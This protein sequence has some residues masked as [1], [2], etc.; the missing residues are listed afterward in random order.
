[1]EERYREVIEIDADDRSGP[2]IAGATRR[3]DGLRRMASATT[4][5]L[6]MLGRGLANVAAIASG[7]VIGQALY[8]LPNLLASAASGARDDEAA[9]LRLEQSIRNLGG[10]FDTNLARVNDA[11]TAGQKLAFTDDEI[12]DSYQFLATATDSSNEALRRQRIALDFARGANIPLAQ[13]SKL[14]GKVTQENIQQFKRLGI[15]IREG[16]TEQEALAAIQ[17]KFAGQAEIYANSSK[18]QAEAANMAFGEMQETLG[19]S[20]LPLLTRLGRIVIDNLPALQSM[21]EWIGGKLSAGVGLALDQLE[22]LQRLFVKWKPALSTAADL[23][24]AFLTAI[25]TDPG[26]LG[27]VGDILERM[28]GSKA[29]G[30]MRSFLQIGMSLI[31]TVGRSAGAFKNLAEGRITVADVLVGIRT[32]FKDFGA[33]VWREVKLLGTRVL[34]TFKTEGPKWVRASWNWVKSAAKSAGRELGNL[35]RAAREWATNNGP[36]ELKD[37]LFGLAASAW[38]W[39]TAAANDADVALGSLLNPVKVWGIT[40]GPRKLSEALEGLAK[41]A[42]EWV[43]TAATGGAN[44]LGDLIE[45]TRTW[46]SGTGPSE[47]AAALGGL[48]DGAWSWLKTAAGNALTFLDGFL[49]TP[50]KQWA[51]SGGPEKL[52]IALGNLAVAAW[53]WVKTA[54]GNAATAMEPLLA[55]IVTWLRESAAPAI[56]ESSKSLGESIYTGVVSGFEEAKRNNEMVAQFADLIERLG[57]SQNFVEGWTGFANAAERVSKWLDAVDESAIA[58]GKSLGELTLKVAPLAAAVAAGGTLLAGLKSISETFKTAGQFAD[59]L[60]LNIDWLLTK[61]GE[62]ASWITANPTIM[63]TLDGIASSATAAANAV[64]GQGASPAPSP[65]GGGDFSN[66]APPTAEGGIVT[67]PQVRLVGEAGPEAIIPLDRAGQ[68]GG[69]DV[70]GV[71]VTLNFHG[72]PLK[73]EDAERLAKRLAPAVALEIVRE[74]RKLQPNLAGAF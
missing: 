30:T 27:V 73:P 24:R 33:D 40:L 60:T 46:A 63:T 17:K 9:T 58:L 65:A 70:G 47:V 52:A 53:E 48:A 59:T 74:V 23:A 5:P 22:P 28:F 61:L 55:S 69:L 11:I 35:I 45:S 29:A 21:V 36:R 57:I 6:R 38:D 51:D 42:W 68:P 19:Y 18:G 8:A 56:L 43:A 7:F 25:T 67:R 20:I 14:L 39:I 4:A 32:I 62:L 64:S 66:E 3:L 37:A 50:I 41:G 31:R 12:R 44:A 15:E 1:M 10:S 16:A 49:I 72:E 26:A 71:A 34:N 2:G 13:A 54:G